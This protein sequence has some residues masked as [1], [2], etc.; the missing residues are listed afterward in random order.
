MFLWAYRKSVN[1]S[2]HT[3]P[4]HASLE[5][6]SSIQKSTNI[7]W[8]ILLSIALF[9]PVFFETLDYT[10]VA[11]AQVHIASSFRRLDLQSWIGT[12]YL[13]TSTVF[14]PLFASVANIWGR[15]D[16]LQASILLFIVGSAISTGSEIMPTMLAGR[17]VA[18]IGAAGLQA[19]VRIIISDWRSLDDNNWQ[20]SMLLFLYAV[21]YCLGP[22]I[23]GALLN[24][25]FRWIFAINGHCTRIYHPQEPDQRT[26]SVRSASLFG[27]EVQNRGLFG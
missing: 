6:N 19:V 16:T 4:S 7:R 17:G 27:T 21:G 9:I 5:V 25:S 15:H 8:R 23:G 10:V 22:V 18:G 14:L 3:P 20:Q 1:K 2:R 13:L 26:S 24:V 11:T 12:S